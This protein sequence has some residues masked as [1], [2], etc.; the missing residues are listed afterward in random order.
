MCITTQ[1]LSEIESSLIEFK[2]MTNNPI[3][4]LRGCFPDINFLRMSAR[5]VDEAPFR[6]L[7]DYNLYLLD[8]SEHCVKITNNPDLA[9]AVVVA[10][11]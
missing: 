9:T 2:N 8:T 5:D 10:Q 11:R 4:L 7:D 1:K 6:A 3:P